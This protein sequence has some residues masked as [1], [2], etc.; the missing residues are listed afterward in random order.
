MSRRLN[1]YIIFGAVF[2]ISLALLVTD[3]QSKTAAI[4]HGEV[5]LKASPVQEEAERY[6]SRYLMQYHFRRV[7]INDSLSQEVLSRFLDQL[8]ETRSYFLASQVESFQKEIGNSIDDEFLAGKVDAGF[9]VYGTFLNQAKQKMRFMIDLLDTAR[10]DFSV[11]ETFNLKSEDIAWPSDQAELQD[12][13]RKEAKYQ[14]LNLKYSGEEP[15]GE[16]REV[17]VKRYKNRLSLLEQ[18]NDE[19]A[20]RAFNYAL[21][22]SFDPHTNYFSPLDYENF[23]I[24]MSH[25][26]EGI[27]AKLQNENEYTVVNEVIPGGPAFRGDLLKKGDRIIGVGQGTKGNVVDIVGWRVNDVVRIIRGKK[28]SVVRLKILPVSQGNKGPAKIIQIVRDEVKLEEQSAQKEIIITNGRKIG[29]IT[30]PAFYLDFEGQKQKK[31]DYSST[32]RDVRK[33]LVE[34][35]KEGVEGI[36]LDL[37]NNGGGALEEAVKLTGLF[38]PEG[39]VVQIKNSHGGMTVLRDKEVDVAYD[40]PLAVLV[41]RYSASASEILAAAIQDYGRGVVIG[42]RTFGKGTVQSILKIN[43]PFNFF[44]KKNDDLGQVK[45]T[46]AKFYRVSGESTQNLGVTPDIK[47]PSFIDTEVVGEDA[48]P[49][50][51][52]WDV[53]SATD[54]LKTGWLSGDDIK[55]LN[56]KYHERV[57][58]D[59][60]YVR[61]L[62]DLDLLSS[63]RKKEFI[64]LYEPDFK[65]EMDR[66]QGFDAQWNEEDDPDILLTQSAAVVA[67]MADLSGKSLA[68]REVAPLQVNGK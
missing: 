32:S 55:V 35:K 25:S 45:L 6:L 2:L 40:G 62:E 64:S 58:K 36:V 8:D 11:S 66:I 30:V 5:A 65:V 22:T 46:I 68:E 7:P 51:L 38:I 15:D 59:S 14:I 28:G 18:Q 61:Y 49:S 52:Q 20:F 17:L 41:N 33:I 4:P 37:R 44:Y 39:P 48:Y 9:M 10:F 67:D 57:D 1:R 56:E 63:F 34:L 47:I 31:P 27:G 60:L 42:G 21:T 13:W 54:H 24:D 43:R 19:D 12:R 50:S 3:V 53:V 23:Q 16:P 29:V 26:F